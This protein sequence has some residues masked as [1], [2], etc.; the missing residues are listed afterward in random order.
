MGFDLKAIDRPKENGPTE[1]V[2]EL[3]GIQ[4]NK[5]K[6]P[7]LQRNTAQVKGNQ[8]VLPK[9]I[10]VKVAVNGHPAQALLDSGSL[11]DFMSSTLADQLGVE[12]T[13]LEAPLALQLAVQG[14]RSKVNSVVT[15]QF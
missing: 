7:A 15:V 2:L 11:G 14:S 12:K 13:T 1:E 3:E 10:V 4:V 9:P 5:N 6:Y 8:R